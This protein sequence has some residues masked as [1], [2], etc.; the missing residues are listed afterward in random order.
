MTKEWEIKIRFYADEEMA[1][2]TRD[3]LYAMGVNTSRGNFRHRWVKLDEIF[4]GEEQ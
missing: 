2:E 3:T 1:R 4:V